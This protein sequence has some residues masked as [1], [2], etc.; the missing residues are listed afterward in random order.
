MVD[1]TIP[2]S[3]DHL[4]GPRYRTEA[5][6]RKHRGWV[7]LAIGV[8]VI[9]LSLGTLAFAAVASISSGRAEDAA[10]GAKTAAES[11]RESNADAAC[12]SVWNAEV[13]DARAELDDAIAIQYALDLNLDILQ[14]EVDKNLGDALE[15]GLLLDD[16]EAVDRAVATRGEFLEIIGIV[17]AAISDIQV[18]IEDLRT[19]YAAA[20][21]DYQAVITAQREDRKEFERLCDAGPR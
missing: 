2:P 17:T 20:N 4:H 9:V 1:D 21:D 18:E 13:V 11:V 10:A 12:R 15:A 5:E 19:V 7:T 14:G 16:Q 3:E 6:D 8:S